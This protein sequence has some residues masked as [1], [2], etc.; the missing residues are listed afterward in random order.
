M[1]PMPLLMSVCRDV[2]V[3]RVAI[4]FSMMSDVL[5]MSV[6]FKMSD[7]ISDAR[8]KMIVK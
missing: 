4:N 8:L 3:L 2:D 1:L 5:L 7:V 6:R